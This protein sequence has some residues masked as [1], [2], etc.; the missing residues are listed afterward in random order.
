MRAKNGTV[1]IDSGTT[2]AHTPVVA[3]TTGCVDGSS[4]TGRMMNGVTRKPLMSAPSTRY[5]RGG[6]SALLGAVS[7]RTSA[8]GVPASTMVGTEADTTVSVSN[9]PCQMQSIVSG[10]MVETLDV[11]RQLRRGERVSRQYATRCHD[12][13]APLYMA[14]DVVKVGA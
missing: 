5:M 8:G 11:L 14:L 2:A 12:Q 10:D 13:Q 9:K 4:T 1:L 3:P 7:T 6:S